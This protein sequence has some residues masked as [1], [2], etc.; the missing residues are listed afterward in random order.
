MAALT[1]M[2]PEE[3][4]RAASP[5]TASP[6]PPA[7]S[8]GAGP[9]SSAQKQDGFVAVDDHD[10]DGQH[11]HLPVPRAGPHHAQ[12]LRR[13]R[14]HQPEPEPGPALGARP[15]RCSM[16]HRELTA[17]GLGDAG[18]RTWSPTSS[19]APAPTAASSRSRPRTRPATACARR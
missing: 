10:A 5:T 14:P 16:L 4:S 11:Q 13:Q 8:A 15:S 18:R 19:P 2:A 6:P 9:T 3:P 17:I 7:S 12:V 1:Q